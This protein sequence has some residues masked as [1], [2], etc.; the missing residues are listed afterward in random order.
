[1][2]LFPAVLIGGPPNSGKS[3]LTHN[4]TLALR[5]RGVEHYVLRAAPDGEGDWAS[6]ADQALVRTIVVP[7]AW[8]PAFVEH[9]CQSLSHRHL[10]LIVDVGGRPAVWQEAIF[11]HCTHAIL[12][13]LDDPSHSAWLDLVT[14]H[15]LL[16]LADLRSELHGLSVVTA[17]R[18]MLTGIIAE[19]EWGS[20]ITGP[21][22]DA[23]VEQ[24]ARIFA[25]APDELRRSHLISAPVE[26][27]VDLDSLARTL[28]VPF[29]GERVTW[30]PH[31][32]PDLLDYL[33]EATPLGL[34]GRAPNWLYA[35]VA[36]FT[37][38][39]LFYQFDVRLGWVTPPA[40][41]LGPPAPDAP[42]QASITPQGDHTRLEFA[43]PTGYL[44]YDD[45]GGLAVPPIP[46]DKGVV[47]SGK[48]SLWLYTGLALTYAPLVPWLAVYQPQVGCVVAYSAD[49]A[50]ATGDRIHDAQS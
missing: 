28:G 4:L 10:P 7:R 31:H 26:N 21:T 16:L 34:Y 11:D 48:L 22:F 36:L 40:L 18:P 13:T 50:H 6:E 3:V 27:A 1:M 45:A 2:E 46:T 38:P 30:Q 15:N 8:T 33:P 49:E 43:I 25:Y 14:R 35:T 5:E 24:I 17:T 41:R 29:T 32:L 9:V 37:H 12:L 42:L 47:L 20:R 23:L 39:A 19:L 44:D